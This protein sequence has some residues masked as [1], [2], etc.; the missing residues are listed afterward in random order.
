MDDVTLHY[1]EDDQGRLQAL[2][3]TGLFHIQ[4]LRLNR[5]Q[6]VEHRRIQQEERLWQERIERLERMLGDVNV[7]VEELRELAERLRMSS[8]DLPQ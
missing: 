1:R 3:A 7:S 4:K 5:P 6:L 8:D 2:S